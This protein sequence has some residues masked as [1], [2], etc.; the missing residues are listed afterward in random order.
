MTV[1]V[2]VLVP[3]KAFGA[4][5]VRLSGA[6]NSAE[7]ESLARELAARVVAAATPLPVAV[8]C[9][10][11]AVRDWAVGAGATVIW[12]PGRGLNGAVTDGVAALGAADVARVIVAHGDLPLAHDLAWVAGFS[13]VTLVPDRH[14][15]GTNVACVPTGIGFGFSYGPGSFRRHAAEGRRLR[16]G[17][18]V[19]RHPGLGWDV[20]LPDDLRYPLSLS[21]SESPEPVACP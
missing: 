5:K 15:D 4:A 1:P 12:R 2:A 10:D 17:V 14:D 3:V 8:V 9:D 11:D 19:V 13:G 20:D 21:A 6:L 16:L 18:R 7:R